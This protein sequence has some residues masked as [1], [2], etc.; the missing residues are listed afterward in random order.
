MRIFVLE[1]TV[2]FYKIVAIN[3]FHRVLHTFQCAINLY[4][5]QHNALRIRKGQQPVSPELVI[6]F[7][8]ICASVK[9]PHFHI[10]QAESF[11]RAIFAFHIISDSGGSADILH[12]YVLNERAIEGKRLETP[13]RVLRGNIGEIHIFNVHLTFVAVGSTELGNIQALGNG[14]VGDSRMSDS[15]FSYADTKRADSRSQNA[16]G[17]GYKFAVDIL[18]LDSVLTAPQGD[19]IVACLNDAVRYRNIPA[20]IDINAIR[21]QHPDGIFDLNAPDLHIFTAKQEATP[22]R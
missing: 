7:R 15:T 6:L 10:A 11:Y 14:D 12:G 22:A 3:D 5:I 8:K 21:V 20:G 13:V 16:I 18:I 9:E 17:Y 2:P 19:G 4:A 1:I